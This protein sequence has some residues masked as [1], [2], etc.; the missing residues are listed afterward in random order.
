MIRLFYTVQIFC[1]AL[2]PAELSYFGMGAPYLIRFLTDSAMPQERFE[3][4]PSL[5]PSAR[6]VSRFRLLKTLKAREDRLDR[7]G[8][9]MTTPAFKA[10]EAWGILIP[11]RT[12]TFVLR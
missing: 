12:L 7:L 3:V 6:N 11:C 5:E 9:P 4:L 10:L 8:G 2:M 1:V